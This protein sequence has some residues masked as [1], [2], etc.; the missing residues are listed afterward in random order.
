MMTTLPSTACIAAASA[1]LP[2]ASLLPVICDMR[3]TLR[4]SYA[5]LP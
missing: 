5:P 1:L 3:V 4:A 2:V